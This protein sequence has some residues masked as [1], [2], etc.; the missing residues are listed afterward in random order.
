VYDKKRDKAAPWFK[1][2]CK[3][4]IGKG[5]NEMGGGKSGEGVGD[6]GV[7]QEKRGKNGE[8]GGVG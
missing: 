6:E 5:M 2:V 1:R 4:L 8:P 3:V 7:A